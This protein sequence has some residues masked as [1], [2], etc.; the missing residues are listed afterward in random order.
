MTT[1]TQDQFQ[2]EAGSVKQAMSGSTSSDLWKVPREKLHIEPGFNVRVHD[3]DYNAHVRSI[4][5]SIKENG[6][7]P[8]KPIAGF[9]AK[10]DGKDVIVVT[11]G[12]SRIAGFDLAVSEGY[13]G[14]ELPVVT[15]PRGT[16]MEDLTIALVTSNTG[17]PLSPYEL[18][19]K[20]QCQA[21]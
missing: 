21:R 3:A 8:D 1:T 15:K 9:V 5:D 13:E 18:G 19:T 11:D 20:D 14:T 10:R 17:K 6:Y 2:F 12:H 4:A 16:S 7:Y